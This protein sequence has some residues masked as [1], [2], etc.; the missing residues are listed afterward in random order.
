MLVIGISCP[1]GEKTR[2]KMSI[3]KQRYLDYVL[4]EKFLIIKKSEYGAD[5]IR[6]LSPC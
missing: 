3:T 6:K 4:G 1:V 2:I 5:Y